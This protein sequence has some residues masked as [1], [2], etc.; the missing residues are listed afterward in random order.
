MRAQL[1]RRQLLAGAALAATAAACGNGDED[2]PSAASPT[3]AKPAGGATSAALDE[4]AIRRKV[5]SLLVVG[6][7]GTS[8]P[9]WMVRAVRD[10]GI[11]GII[12]FDTDQLTGQKRNIISP[13]Q[14][15][16]LVSSLQ[17]AGGG[18]LIVSIDQE[19]GQISRLNPSNGFPASQ[20]QEQVGAVNQAA[21]TTAWAQGLVNSM[22]SI[23][24]TMNYAPVVDLD[25]N[26]SNPAIGEL[27]RSFSADPNIVVANA[28]E[29]IKVHR[30]GRIKTSIKHFPGFGSA[31]GN[32]DFDVVD[33]SSTWKRAELEPFQRLIDTGMTD[34]VLV[35]H[36]LNKQLDAERPMSLSRKVVTDL[37]RGRL[38]WQ[39]PVVSDDMQATGITER[40]STADAFTFAV[41]AGVDLLVYAN[42]QVYN[43]K[44]V[45]E[46]LG[47]AVQRVRSGA[48]T[49]AQIDA[50]VARVDKLRP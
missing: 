30:A 11:G 40:Y 14:A 48:L 24:A 9:D 13:A 26:P 4:A 28:T 49:M 2:T 19:G 43:T 6:F 44:I 18:N 47:V 41:Q 20:S 39:G 34:S 50:A 1:S 35:A 15:K 5:A 38:G 36:L 33:V 32:T 8:A 16:A 22:K 37:L 25:V 3:T 29:E 45:D 17:S 46:L 27:G 21:H 7:R 42:Q 23:G 31:T 10:H 12:L